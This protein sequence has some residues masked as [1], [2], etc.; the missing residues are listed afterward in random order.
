MQIIP[1]MKLYK[2]IIGSNAMNFIIIA[3]IIPKCIIICRI[4]RKAIVFFSP[5]CTGKVLIPAS[6][7]PF[8]SLKSYIIEF[9]KTLLLKKAKTKIN[10]I[11]L[12]TDFIAIPVMKDP[13]VKATTKFLIPRP[14]LSFKLNPQIFM[15]LL[16]R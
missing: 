1:A 10:G 5:N 13:H 8:T 14:P 16:Y 7:S 12:S 11:I 9:M 4:K 3:T 2:S 6:E 15:P